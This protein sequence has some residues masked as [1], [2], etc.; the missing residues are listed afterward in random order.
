MLITCISLNNGTNNWLK[1][2]KYS[3]F[4]LNGVNAFKIFN[5]QKELKSSLTKYHYITINIG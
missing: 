3:I 4:K 1:N 2:R 5:F